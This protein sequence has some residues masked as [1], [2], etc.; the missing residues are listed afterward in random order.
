[1]GRKDAEPG[2]RVCG[3]AEP[4]FRLQE[5]QA[6]LCELHAAGIRLQGT[7]KDAGQSKGPETRSE[8]WKLSSKLLVFE[9]AFKKLIEDLCEELGK[10]LWRDWAQFDKKLQKELR[11]NLELLQ[12]S[13]PLCRNTLSRTK[14]KQRTSRAAKGT[15]RGLSVQPGRA[16]RAAQV[17]GAP[18]AGQPERGAA[19]AKC[20]AVGGNPAQGAPLQAV[21]ESAAGFRPNGP[22][23]RQAGLKV[24][25]DP[26][27]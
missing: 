18:R 8:P 14:R 25:A 11:K 15:F 5:K 22:A 26:F 23:H 19:L 6:A 1:M 9:R 3:A 2:L 21:E 16:Q 4:G 17:L 24:D 12:K 10:A 27:D 7:K 20:S 13:P